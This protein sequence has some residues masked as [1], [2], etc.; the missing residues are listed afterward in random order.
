MKTI[1]ALIISAL[2]IFTIRTYGQDKEGPQ[3]MGGGG[4]N[5]GVGSMDVSK[6][7]VFVPDLSKLSNQQILLGG[8]GHGFINKLA[9]GGTGSAI[10]GNGMKTSD[11]KVSYGGGYGTFDLGYMII[12][13]ERFKIYPLFGLG[14]GGYGIKI[15]SNQDLSV[16][17]I[18]SNPKRE[19]DLS[20]GSFV[21]DVSL[22]LNALPLVHYDAIDNSYGGLMTGVRV[23]YVYG[24]P[25]SDWTYEGGDVNDGPN[26]GINMF[27]VKLVIGGFGYSKK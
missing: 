19:I 18:S 3:S 26:F 20:V 12:N 7:Q 2:L 1:S 25:T 23:G 13:K 11:L 5:I 22:N 21:M 9:I 27:Y 24:F 10:I 16:N 14:G 8:T 15:S 17:D 6:L 4:F